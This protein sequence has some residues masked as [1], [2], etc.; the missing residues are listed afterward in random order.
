M[1][2]GA[3]SYGEVWRFNFREDIVKAYGKN[4]PIT[5]YS[6]WLH[7]N[8]IP[9]YVP[10]VLVDVLKTKADV[11]V[12]AKDLHVYGLDT[13]AG[14]MT[15]SGVTFDSNLD[16]LIAS[17]L[18]K[19][20]DSLGGGVSIYF[21]H[22]AS[23]KDYTFEYT[24]EIES[25][26]KDEETGEF[27]KDA[28]GKKYKVSKTRDEPITANFK[29]NFFALSLES[30]EVRGWTKYTISSKGNFLVELL[31]LREKLKA[32]ILKTVE[33]KEDSDES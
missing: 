28:N 30:K 1:Y 29:V 2:L 17:F 18:K 6:N 26:A 4:I 20:I 32:A 5:T 3:V 7:R 12:A 11:A 25:W 10:L 9:R 33:Y 31:S 14:K 23:R 24:Q 27:L 21:K 19:N 15:I 13:Q 16:D 22:V 8:S